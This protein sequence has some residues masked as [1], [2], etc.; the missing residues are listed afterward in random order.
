MTPEGEIKKL[1]DQLEE[2]DKTIKT[3]KNSMEVNRYN[4][5]KNDIRDYDK[6]IWGTPAVVGAIA[7]AVLTMVFSSQFQDIPITIKQAILMTGAGVDIAMFVGLCKHRFFQQYAH[8]LIEELESNLGFT[9]EDYSTKKIFE[10][11]KI[12][13]GIINRT[14]AYY[15]LAGSHIITIAALISAFTYLSAEQ[16]L[17]LTGVTVLFCFIVIGG[18]AFIPSKKFPKT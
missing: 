6:L 5:L 13:R 3:L 10:S 12:P 1:K 14:R 16:D 2:M 11:E 15:W 18:V 17:I 8:I 9:H 4:Q 7:A